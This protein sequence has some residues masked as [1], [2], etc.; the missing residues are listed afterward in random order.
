MR[1]VCSRVL[2]SINT[3][4]HSELYTSMHVY[5]YTYMQ[6]VLHMYKN[7][8]VYVCGWNDTQISISVC[9]C[10]YV[11][12]YKCM[13]VCVYSHKFTHVCMYVCV[14]VVLCAYVWFWKYAC[15]TMQNIIKRHTRAA[16]PAKVEAVARLP[17]FFYDVL[18]SL[19]ASSC[20]VWQFAT[21]YCTNGQSWTRGSISSVACV[22]WCCK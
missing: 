18:T 14:C 1:V 12:A 4:M 16:P 3:Y 19:L 11:C 7:R 15:M 10:V 20:A 9:V 17:A 22:P 6:N 8:T 21:A 5:I 2:H 13:L